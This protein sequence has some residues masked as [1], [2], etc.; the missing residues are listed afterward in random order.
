MDMS[1][2]LSDTTLETKRLILRPF[3]KADL[4][5]FYEYASVP[6][7]GEMA[8][9]PHHSSKAA[10]AQILRLMIESKEVLAVCH[11]KNGKVIGSL[12]LHFSWVNEDEQFK[13]LSVKEVGY[14]L[15][16]E[17]WGQGLIPE[18]VSAVIEYCFLTV[19]LD[20]LSCSHFSANSQSLRVIEKCGFSFVKEGTYFSMQLQREFGDCRYI[21]LNPRGTAGML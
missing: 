20:A 2:D 15:S 9:W 3:K 5:D 7:V 8:G 19:G 18:A 10:S 13:H 17:F 21:R 12:G 11:K 6:G 16:K 4:D 1:I 14:V